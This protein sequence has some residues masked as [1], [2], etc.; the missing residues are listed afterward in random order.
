MKFKTNAIIGLIFIGLFGFVYFYEIKGGEERRKEA[1]KSKQLL[2][3]T[4]GHVSRLQLQRGDTTLVLQKGNEGWNFSSPVK[5][6]ADRDAVERYLRNLGESEREKVVVDSASS[7][8]GEAEKYGLDA[9]RLTVEIEA[10][11]GTTQEVRWGDDSPTDRFTYAQMAG[12]NPE[13]FVVRAWRFDNLN[14]GLFDLRDRRVL[15]ISKDEVVE[16]RRRTP[17]GQLLLARE[18]EGWQM[19]QPLTSAADVE[20]V[21][22]LLDKIDGAQIEAFVDEDPE[23]DALQTYGLDKQYSEWTFVVG[24]D[25]AEKRLSIGWSDG[26]GSFYARDA[27]R[28]QVFLVDSTVV[29]YTN[30][31]IDQLRDRKPLRFVRDTITGIRLAKG[32]ERVFEAAKD[33]SGLWSLT[34]S[35]TDAKSWKLNSLVGDMEQ[36]EVAGFTEQVPEGSVSAL[37]IELISGEQVSLSIRVLQNEGVS[38]LQQQGDNS[39]YILAEDDFAELALDLEDVAQS[40]AK[41]AE[42]AGGTDSD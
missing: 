2:D 32:G 10:E 19:L 24:P 28:Q 1:E 34:D 6:S 5:D 4:E 37:E 30:K 41:S 25:R 16:I 27:S 23:I 33:T 17:D 3:F 29:Q 21:N 31:S 9:P 22:A 38:Y 18:T 35:A 13:I 42:S 11:D 40:P 26:Q 14:K 39:V 8:T 15:A 36:L 20:A 12:V 7:T